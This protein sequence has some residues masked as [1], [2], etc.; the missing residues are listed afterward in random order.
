MAQSIH[1]GWHQSPAPVPKYLPS[2]SVAA[3]GVELICGASIPPK[4]VHWI[5]LGWIPVGR[6]VIVAGQTGIGKTTSVLMLAA[7]GSQGSIGGRYWPGQVMAPKINVVI[8]SGE[9]DIEEDLVPCLIASGADMNNIYFVSGRHPNGD[10]REFDFSE[11]DIAGLNEKISQVGN[12]GMVIIDSIV[13]AVPGNSNG[14]QAVRRALAPLRKLARDHHCAIVGLTHVNKASKGK[15][16]VDRITGSLAFASTSRGVIIVSKINSVEPNEENRYVMV[17]AKN[18]KGKPNGGFEYT[19]QGVEFGHGVDTIKTAIS[20]INDTPLPGTAEQILEMAEGKTVNV[21]L[22]KIDA[23]TEF[24]SAVLAKGP[25]HFSVIKEKAQM[26]N[27]SEG[28]LERAK[29]K[30]GVISEKLSG[31]GRASP[32]TWSLPG[33]QIFGRQL[34]QS[35]D[36]QPSCEQSLPSSLFPNPTNWASP[37]GGVNP[38]IGDGI[39]QQQAAY[40]PPGH[41]AALAGQAGYFGVADHAGVAGVAGLA[42]QVGHFGVA[43]HAGVAAPAGLE[44]QVGLQHIT[45]ESELHDQVKADAGQGRTLTE[46]DVCDDIS[47]PDPATDSYQ[48][49]SSVAGQSGEPIYAINQQTLQFLVKQCRSQLR[50]RQN[51]H[52]HD[53]DGYFDVDEHIYQIMRQVVGQFHEVGSLSDDEIDRSEKTQIHQLES[54][55]WWKDFN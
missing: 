12:V 3:N 21:G 35:F 38:W 44:G 43:D 34:D 41:S 47:M 27:I 10:R 37:F 53:D 13:Q 52:H 24:L 31:M 51:S 19:I 1:T 8:W 32:F 7:I 26:A 5:W 45:A 54:T 42:G 36:M 28:T 23:A 50:E 22:S 2:K 30:L 48:M 39:P 29:A 6:I 14:N 16:P 55:Y 33:Q 20:C 40:V 4:P 25:V 49:N 17:Q 46:L 9:D 15:N 11:Q 18:Q